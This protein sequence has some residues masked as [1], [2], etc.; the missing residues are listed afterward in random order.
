[1]NIL[2]TGATGHVGLTLVNRLLAEGHTVRT[3]AFDSGKT[4]DMLKKAGVQHFHADI[5]QPEQIAPAFEGVELVYHLA[6][7]VSYRDRG[8]EL[9]KA[10]NVDG[11][12]NVIAAC[13]RSGVRRLLHFSSIEAFSPYPV[14]Q[15]LDET[16]AL[17]DEKFK[18]PYPRSKAMGQRLVVEAIQQGLDAVIVYPTA[19][20]GPYDYAFRAANRVMRDLA[21]GNYG[22]LS[23]GGFNFVDVR[24]VVEVAIKAAETAKSG[25][26]YLAAGHWRMFL[27]MGKIIAEKRG[28]PIPKA[29]VSVQQLEMIAPIASFFGELLH[30]Q[31]LITG[32]AVHAVTHWGNVSHARAHREL[33]YTPRP[34]ETTIH[35]TVQWFKEN[36]FLDA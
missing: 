16:R 23:A 11:V 13:R 8:F 33:G 36:G 21:R 9:M 5:T 29:R 27:E 35:E 26:G 17:V 24:D 25:A 6:A 10:V 19:V 14:D 22:S 28:D 15:E 20:I 34:F 3:L 7:L 31:P 32:A 4:L 2:V 12:R 18:Y 1:M 30:R